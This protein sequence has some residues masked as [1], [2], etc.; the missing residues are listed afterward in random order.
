MVCR[1]I[2]YNNNLIIAESALK[3][4]VAQYSKQA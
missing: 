2:L 1:D 4:L 3:E